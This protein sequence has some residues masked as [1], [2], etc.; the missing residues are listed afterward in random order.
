MGVAWGRGYGSLKG[1]TGGLI[2]MAVYLLATEVH[3]IQLW[4]LN[5]F[6][7]ASVMAVLLI[8]ISQV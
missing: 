2:C 4:W 3:L 5:W 1:S 6:K 8:V 7:G